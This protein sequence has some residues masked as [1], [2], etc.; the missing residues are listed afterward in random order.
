MIADTIAD[1]VNYKESKDFNTRFLSL[2]R[3]IFNYTVD[4]YLV[5]ISNKTNLKLSDLETYF[6]S[7]AYKD[8]KLYR[9]YQC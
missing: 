2:P 1:T 5:P 6:Q 8:Y 7:L 9:W 4:L 3:N